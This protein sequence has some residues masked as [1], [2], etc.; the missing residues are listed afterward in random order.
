MK[1]FW[2]VFISV[3]VTILSV[4]MLLLWASYRYMNIWTTKEYIS[5]Y[6]SFSKVLGDALGNLDVN[7]EAL[8]HNAA[9]IVADLDDR[10]G[11]LST[12]KL[13]ELRDTLNVSHIF[14]VNNTGNFIR[15]TNEDPKLIP[16]AF[17]FCDD[18]RNLLTGRRKFAATPIVRPNPE[19]KPY[20]FL[21]LPTASRKRLIEVGVRVDFVA[22]TLTKALGADP[23]LV[24]VSLYSPVGE[25]FGRFS[26]EGVQFGEGRTKV[27]TEF[28]QMIENDDVIRY[29]M[30]LPSSHPKCC[31]CEVAGTSRNG[32][33]YYVLESEI[34]KQ[35]LKEIQASMKNIFF[36][37][38]CI[39]VLLALLMSHYVSRRLVVNIEEA[40][41]KLK[42]IMSGGPAKRIEMVGQDEV[43]FLTSQFDRLLD[44]LEESQQKLVESERLKA[45][46]QLAREVAHNI[47]S[48]TLAIDMI[49]PLLKGVPE[50][51]CKILRDSAT[52][53]RRLTERL[54][55]QA[56]E[57]DKQSVA[58]LMPPESVP[59]REFL[60]DIVGRK[61]LEH[62]EGHSPFI[63]LRANESFSRAIVSADPS[64]LNAVISN[65]INN[66]TESYIEKIG[67]VYVI[68]DC[69]DNSCTIT[70]KDMGRGIPPNVLEKIGHEEVTS[71]KDA[72]QGIGLLHAYKVVGSLGGRISIDSTIGTGTTVKITLPCVAKI[73]GLYFGVEKKC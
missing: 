19:V 44:Q 6:S 10:E 38:I 25:V 64:E 8:M 37:L 49:M 35:G 59:L 36:I 5:R 11:P 31:Q 28:P 32:E 53:I 20:K 17:S 69:S 26:A 57:D 65:L 24:S 60:E 15:S 22:Q 9:R 29:F 30:K 1:F 4:G 16:N 39:T 23:N 13:K 43:V 33:Y 66:A 56:D 47:K 40:V 62:N 21:F 67:L 58:L 73:E 70:I 27:P 50:N 12:E 42:A 54:L 52:D 2:K 61:N 14:V 63:I 48:P 72:G 18:Y 7:T 34:S 51:V 45:K 41:K 68:G 55:R 46:V 71:G 3:F